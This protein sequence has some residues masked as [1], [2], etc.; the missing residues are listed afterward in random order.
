MSL[1]KIL[2]YSDNKLG[3]WSREV[4]ETLVSVFN[5]NNGAGFFKLLNS[6][7]KISMILTELLR[8]ANIKGV[9]PT[10]PDTYSVILL[11]KKC[12]NRNMDVTEKY[13]SKKIAFS[14]F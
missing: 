12:Y 14:I 11:F 1:T 5:C 9:I 2:G 7:I 8:D 3:N 4:D 13:F 10:S 6:L